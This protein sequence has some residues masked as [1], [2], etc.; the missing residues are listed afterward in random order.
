MLQFIWESA[1]NFEGIC[2]STPGSTGS[3]YSDRIHSR[4]GM[5]PRFR[6]VLQHLYRQ[7]GDSVAARLRIESISWES[8]LGRV[9]PWR[10]SSISVR[11][12]QCP[13]GAA[14]VRQ[15]RFG[16]FSPAQVRRHLYRRSRI[17]ISSRHRKNDPRKWICNSRFEGVTAPSH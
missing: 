10:N 15:S 1:P 8:Q 17:A 11:R 9:W 5:A 13:N 7:R 4:Q 3:C 6:E 14:S 12:C 2:G 16:H